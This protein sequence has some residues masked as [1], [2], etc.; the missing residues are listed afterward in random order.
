[1][2]ASRENVFNQLVS[3][4]S[5]FTVEDA[6]KLEEQ[7]RQFIA[8]KNL[9]RCI[10]NPEIFLKL[11]VINALLSYQ[12]QMTGENYW[13]AFSDFFSRKPVMDAFPEFLRKFNKRFL[14]ARLRRFEKSRRCVDRIFNRYSVD[15]IGRNLQILVDELS[16][17][18]KQKKTAKTV[19]FAA[20]MFM[21][22]YRIVFNRDPEGIESIE[23]PLDSRLKKLLPT[24]EE[25]RELAE[26]LNIPPIHLDALVWI[27][28]NRA[29][30]SKTD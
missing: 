21:Y 18:L 10:G 14:N 1:M 30:R 28:M 19:V 12:L 11:V 24:V 2:S 8:L 20:K 25:W 7:D 26:K 4:L 5:R 13:E 17:C 3:E 23:I 9:Y 16:S 29:N 15:D 6:R 27:P 22:G